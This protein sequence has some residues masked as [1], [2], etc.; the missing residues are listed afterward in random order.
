MAIL[1]REA[2][3]EIM[4]KVIKLSQADHCEVN[5][6][7]NKG[8]NIRYARNT[9][10]TSGEEQNTTL[11]VESAFG[12][13]TGT[14]SINEFDDESLEKVVR[15]SEE[16]AQLAP[17]NPEYME[18]LGPQDYKESTSHFDSTENI[19]PDYRA[20]AAEKSIEPSKGNGLVA[21]GF[22]VDGVSFRA[23]MNSNGLFAYH[24]SSSVDFSV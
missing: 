24:E 13:K 12:K 10:T 15:R 17:E 21:A 5:L 19:T 6:Q 7:G 2:A 23:I 18:P 22:L 1:T 8:G 20:D 4:Q 11:S 3:K 16:L 9:V 14:A